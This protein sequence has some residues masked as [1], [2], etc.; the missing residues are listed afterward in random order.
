MRGGLLGDRVLLGSSS[1]SFLT[2]S[3]GQRLKEGVQCISFFLICLLT[4]A[5]FLGEAFLGEA[6][7]REAFLGEAFLPDPE[8]RP[9]FLGEA[10]LEGEAVDAEEAEDDALA[11]RPLV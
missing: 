7:L 10:D 3:N 1:S 9:L 4:L 8:G 2:R 11:G 6:F 5:A